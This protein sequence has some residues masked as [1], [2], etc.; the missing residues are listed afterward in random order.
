MRVERALI[1]ALATG[2]LLV[3]AIASGG[4]INGTV[5]D[6]E[7]NPIPSDGNLE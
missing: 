7:G 3:S 6:S 4:S 2:M 1:S 5:V